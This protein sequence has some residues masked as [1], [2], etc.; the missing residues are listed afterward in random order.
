MG[1]K[2]YASVEDEMKAIINQLPSINKRIL[3]S[4]TQSVK[5]PTFVGLDKPITINYLKNA[6]SKLIK[7]FQK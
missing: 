6:T 7:L 3:T 4:A 5:I 2:G 1:K